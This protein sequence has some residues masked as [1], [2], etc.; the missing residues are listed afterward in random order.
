MRSLAAVERLRVPDPEEAVAPVLEAIGIVRRELA[1][2]QAVVGF[3][4]GPFTVAGYLVEG[5]PSREFGV[6]KTLM[7]RE[8]EVWRA[9]LDK[10]ADTFAAYTV[11][12]A[13]A[14]ADV[15]QL[16]DSWVGS[17]SVGRLR[18]VRRAVVGP[19]PRRAARR[20]ACPRSTSA[21]ARR[22]CLARWR[23]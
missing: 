9:L 13:R 16:F 5:K 20:R 19:R 21:P 15:V 23:P 10:L 22:H 3:C 18:G 11:A 6:T 12:Q 17:L 7:Y 2:E 14:G 8:P 4:G 1:P